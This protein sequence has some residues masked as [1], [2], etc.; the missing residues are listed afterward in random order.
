MSLKSAGA[1]LLAF[2]A[3]AAVADG[4]GRRGRPP[5]GPR[6][7]PATATIRGRVFAEDT[8]VPLRRALVSAQGGGR[9]VVGQTD[10]DGWF[11]I[12]VPPGRWSLAAA[13][14]GYVT[15]RLG[16]RRAFESVPPVE[17]RAGQRM[18]DADFVLP[19][20]AAISGRVL[21]ELGD[22]VLDARVRVL[23][24]QMVRGRKR[25]SSAGVAVSTDDR[26]AYRLYGLA[27]GQYYVSA[28]AETRPLDRGGRQP[29]KYA[30]TY[31]PGTVN[32]TDAQRIVVDVGDEQTNVNFLLAPVATARVSGTAVD[33]SGSPLAGGTINLV[34]PFESADGDLTLGASTRIEQDGRFT[35]SDVVPGAY[36]LVARSRPARRGNSMTAPV[37]AYLPLVVPGDIGGVSV[38][39]TTGAIL[40]GT[41]ADARGGVPPGNV[42]IVA[43]PLGSAPGFGRLTSNTPVDGAF[44]LEGL[45]GPV[46]FRPA[47]LPDG[48][49][50]DRIEV[51]G[52]DVTDTYVEFTGTER[53]L[54]RVVLSNQ[55]SQV[56]GRV[57]AARRSPSGYHVVVFPA[58]R[59]KWSYPSRYVLST[60]S[61]ED[62]RFSLP[63]LP[64]YDRYLAVA[65]DYLEDDESTDPDFLQAVRGVA[66]P[67]TLGE[68][69]AEVLDLKLVER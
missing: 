65:V 31:F 16:Q 6:E 55:V 64:P 62:G 22:P 52:V 50:L 14:P 34:A 26:G 49:S 68:G 3:L 37:M 33:A 45:I 5:A 9:P 13:K 58:D 44:S 59:T 63:V 27:P 18:D 35:I 25:L 20:G 57:T 1:L 12:R 48:W 53:A 29:Q 61:G 24:Y 69:E 46:I 60:R 56:S 8:G 43:Q 32:I 36:I 67:F 66:T 23:R 38:T 4:Q 19:R 2:V 17:V 42:R 7:P 40:S 47:Q 41:F 30:T 15:L 39:A 51:N 54:A 11:E 28:R 21:D 10:M